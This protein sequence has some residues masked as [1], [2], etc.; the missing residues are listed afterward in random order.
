MVLPSQCTLPGGVK[1]EIQG[2][3]TVGSLEEWGRAYFSRYR[4]RLQ[5]QAKQQK[6][7]ISAQIHVPSS[8]PGPRMGVFTDPSLLKDS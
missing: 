2:G 1:L 6:V 7:V 3:L 5:L 4:G 8:S